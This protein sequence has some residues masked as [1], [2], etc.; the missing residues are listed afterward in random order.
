MPSDVKCCFISF[1]SLYCSSLIGLWVEL[2]TEKSPMHS[3]IVWVSTL[4]HYLRNH[5]VPYYSNNDFTNAPNTF[6]SNLST[7]QSHHLLASKREGF[8][9]MPFLQC[10]SLNLK[11]SSLGKLFLR[12]TFLNQVQV[13]A[14]MHP[15]YAKPHK[16]KVLTG[17]LWGCQDSWYP[18][19]EVPLSAVIQLRSMVGDMADMYLPVT[20]GPWVGH[21]TLSHMPTTESH[22]TKIA[23]RTFCFRGVPFELYFL[24][25]PLQSTWNQDANTPWGIFWKRTLF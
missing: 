7:L 18:C 13:T 17:I 4:L 6:F 9:E 21:I 5:Y 3:N 2:R 1:L 20:L 23:S 11:F 19:C 10:L 22:A 15:C 16:W 8:L 14:L 25:L 24:S 12:L